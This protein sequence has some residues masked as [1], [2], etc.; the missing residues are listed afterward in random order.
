MKCDLMHK[1]ISVLSFEY[2][3]YSGSITHIYDIYSPQHIPLGIKFNG[4]TADRYDLNRWWSSRA[5][6]SSRDGLADALEALG[7]NAVAS[8]L[9][10]N[11]GLS[12][13]DQYWIRHDNSDLTWE[14]VNFFDNIFSEDL[15]NIFIGQGKDS[16]NI[17]YLS[18]D[19]TSGGWLKK[20]WKI[21]EGKRVLFKGGSQPFQQEPYNEAFASF[22]MKCLGIPCVDYNIT[23]LNNKPFCVC[24][25]FI[26]RNTELITAFSIINSKKQPNHISR[27][28]HY[29]ERCRELGVSDI[30]DSI[31]RMLVLDFLI[32]NEDRH[33][34]NFGLIRNAD[35]L[36]FIGAAPLYDNGSA[37]WFNTPDIR[38]KAGANEAVCKPFKN[39]HSDQVKLVS[40]FDWLEFSKLNGIEE[41]LSEILQM[42]DWISNERRDRICRAFSDRIGILKGIA[43]RNVKYTNIKSIGS[44]VRTDTAY[45]GNGK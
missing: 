20:K 29:I 38:I 14:K 3:E 2:D 21:I 28:E 39:D 13:S 40:S 1:N 31:D 19:I 22:V 27:Y 42:S 30:R 36:E 6:P 15:G 9:A 7:V 37:L 35:T 24:E 34:N 4:E 8:L 26:D 16:D 11:Y 23:T 44:E 18:P 45:S 33:L 41:K 10:R 17:D 32:V 43:D 5:I 25:D 12:L